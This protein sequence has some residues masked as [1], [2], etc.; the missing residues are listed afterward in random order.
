MCEPL[1]LEM[2]EQVANLGRKAR[3]TDL[4]AAMRMDV[5]EVL[6]ALR[7]AYGDLDDDSFW[8]FPIS[9]RVNICSI[10][11][12]CLQQM[13]DFNGNLQFR[14]N[15]PVKNH[16]RFTVPEERFE[17]W[18][19]GREKLPKAGD[20]FVCMLILAVW[21]IEASICALTRIP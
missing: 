19:V 16:W 5:D 20:T 4:K 1:L 3:N 13:D 9:G 6:L 14:R 15:L 2:Q 10:V 21:S 12:H 11:M 18:G 7:E 8:R 17:F